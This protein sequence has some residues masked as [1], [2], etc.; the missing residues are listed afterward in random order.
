MAR[1]A[2]DRLLEL[3]RLG[4]AGSKECIEKMNQNIKEKETKMGG[5]RTKMKLAK[6]VREGKKVD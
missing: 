6:F 2:L 3:A 4:P 1:R 5:K